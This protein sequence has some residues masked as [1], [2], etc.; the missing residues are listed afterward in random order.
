MGIVNIWLIKKSN[1]L[2]RLR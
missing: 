2:N 1:P